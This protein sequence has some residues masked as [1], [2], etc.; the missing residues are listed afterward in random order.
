MSINIKRVYAN[1]DPDDGIRI[2]VDHLLPR[3]LTKEH[4]KI[5]YWLKELLLYAGNFSKMMVIFGLV[6]K[7][8]K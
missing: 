4:A 2:L 3:R 7:G 6:K 1:P 8:V 5:D